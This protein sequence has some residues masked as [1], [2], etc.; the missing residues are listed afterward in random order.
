MSDYGASRDSLEA[1]KARV[2]QALHILTGEVA[3]IMDEEE[4]A[5]VGDF[6]ELRD[7]GWGRMEVIVVGH[8]MEGINWTKTKKRKDLI[9]SPETT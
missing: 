8:R 2:L 4:R 5:I 9:L 1:R 3:P 7:Y 6:R